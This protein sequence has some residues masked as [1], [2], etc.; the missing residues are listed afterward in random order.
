M[1]G[2]VA[3]VLSISCPF[4]LLTSTVQHS[5]LGSI[6]LRQRPVNHQGTEV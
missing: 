3:G 6:P 4:L 5:V 1:A 2:L